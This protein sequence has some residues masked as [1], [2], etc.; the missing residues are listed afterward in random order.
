MLFAGSFAAFS[1][2][3]DRVNDL[4]EQLL[5][6]NANK[7]SGND[8]PDAKDTVKV[9]ILS[10]LAGLTYEK[11]TDKALEYVKEQMEI[12]QAINHQKGIADSYQNYGHIM[13]INETTS[14]HSS[15]SIRH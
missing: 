8:R 12:S 11:N 13:I 7:K 2:N 6:F 9:K 3:G 15:F 10:E 14:R 1:Q 4:Q 5:Q